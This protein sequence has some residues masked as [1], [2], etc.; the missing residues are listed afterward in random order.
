MIRHNID[1]NA[2]PP[3]VTGSNQRVDVVESAQPRIYVPVVSDVIA[4]ISE[5][6]WIKGAKPH[7]IDAEGS[8]VVDPRRYPRDIPE[9]VTI[10]I[11]K[12]S[13]IDLINDGITPPVGTTS[14]K[15]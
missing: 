4:A 15:N 5:S 7:R 1:E 10:G 8:Q 12:R 11:S 6:R 13:W 9:P 14:Q 2:N 3:A